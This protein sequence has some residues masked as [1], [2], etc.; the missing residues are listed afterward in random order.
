MKLI[1][2]TAPLRTRPS[3]ER[4]ADGAPGA[5]VLVSIGI[6]LTIAGLHEVWHGLTAPT[7]PPWRDAG[8]FLFDAFGWFVLAAAAFELGRRRWNRTVRDPV[9]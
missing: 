8:T 6:A 1:G 7:T 4:V 2:S 3:R 5:L 9:D